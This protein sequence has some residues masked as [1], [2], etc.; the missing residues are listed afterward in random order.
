MQKID[1]TVVLPAYNEEDNIEK[2]VRDALAVLP[3]FCN[4][5][6]V[7][8][9]N[10]GS[11]DRT[12]EIAD[13]LVSEDPGHIRVIHH[14]PNQGY[15]AALRAGFLASETEYTFYTDSDN[16]FDYNDLEKLVPLAPQND[17]VVG[18]R[19]DRQ[20][21]W[22]RIFVSRCYNILV[23]TIF[24]LR[25]RDIDCAFK[26]FRRDIFDKIEIKYH[27][28]L[29]DTEILTKARRLNLRIA[30]VGVRHL[31]RVAGQSTV[32]PWDIF[33]TL[34]G[35]W[36][37]WWTVFQ[38]N[39]AMLL[40]G[41]AI[42]V[43]FIVA[44]AYWIGHFDWNSVPSA[45]QRM[46]KTFLAL[47]LLAYG[48]SFFFRTW[49]WQGILSPI[50]TM[51]M[52]A[53]FP[54]IAVG[55]AGNNL[56]PFRAGELLRAYDLGN[57]RRISKSLVFGTIVVERLLDSLTLILL[58]G[59]GFFLV[60]EFGRNVIWVYVAG[61]LVFIFV[62]AACI[63]LATGT[64]PEKSVF[65]AAFEWFSA[66]L[67][68]TFGFTV[69]PVLE[70]LRIALNERIMFRGLLISFLVWFSEAAMFYCFFRGFGFEFSFLKAV[71]TACVV[72]IGLAIPSFS[73]YAGTF[74]W[75][76][77]LALMAFGVQHG[78]AWGFAVLLHLTQ[79]I[80]ITLIGVVFFQ[81]INLKVVTSKEKSEE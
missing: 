25:V 10:D 69:E 52:A 13:R 73:A 59:I 21:A 67:F 39:W 30:E 14:N 38:V 80:P 62:A 50:V 45:F 55:W 66:S 71:V 46:N 20:D 75:F 77:V 47:S 78:A 61:T 70:G 65:R 7:L 76:C 79:F 23:S 29:V 37:L 33:K 11:R 12:G 54:S 22:I 43:A 16:Q 72:N 35:I 51:R 32:T 18:Y 64:S 57:N 4:R 26:L 44:L 81:R 5:Y 42:S 9:V 27:G 3:K 1:L 58:L 19:Q 17:L 31:P 74:E 34:R 53:L 56:L 36:W 2:S 8:I 40:T 24:S 48:L 6:C 68:K 49:R 15:A 28:F 41:L 60:P 63:Y